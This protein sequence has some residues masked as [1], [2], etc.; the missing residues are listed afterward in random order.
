MLVQTW[1]EV[2]LNSLQNIWYGIAD[3]LPALLLALVVFLVGWLVAELIKKG[4]VHLINAEKLD[5]LL[6]HTG[7]D[8]LV[9]KAGYKLHSGIFIGELVKWFIIVVFLVASLDIVGLTQV[10]FFL[11]EVVL[12]FIPNVIVAALVLLIASVLADIVDKLVTGSAKAAHISS[13]DFLGHAARWAIWIFGIIIA[14]AQLNIAPQFLQIL[15]TGVIAA[16][17]LAGGLAFGLGGRE[18]AADVLKRIGKKKE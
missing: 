5:T 13:A 4:V 7:L 6:E 10:N 8:N 18:A 16:L 17:A 3:F 1:G 11:Q 15:F 9:R 12:V 2:L 14:L